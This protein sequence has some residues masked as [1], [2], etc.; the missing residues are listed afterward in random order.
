MAIILSKKE[1]G[2][3]RYVCD[4]VPV[5]AASLG[6]TAID[7][8][9]GIEY[10][11]LSSG[12]TN[13]TIAEINQSQKIYVDST[14]GVDSAGNGSIAAPY[15]TPEFALSD[16]TNTGTVTGNTNTSV[17]ITNI[18]DVDNAT[19]EVGMYLVGTGIPYGTIIVSKG[20]EGLDA[21]T[22]TISKAATSTTA[23]LSITWYKAYTLVLNGDFIATGNWHKEGFNFEF[24]NSN[25]IF[26]GRLFEITSTK[27]LPLS[28]SGGYLN[29]ISN[30]SQLIYNNFITSDVDFYFG[31]KG[32]YSIG[33]SYQ[34]YL[35][36]AVCFKSLYLD[37][38]RFDARF[39]YLA[40]LSGGDCFWNGYKYGLLGGIDVSATRLFSN[41]FLETP[42]SVNAI[43]TSNANNQLFVNDKIIGSINLANYSAGFV[44]NGDIN[45]T[46]FIGTLSQYYSD[47]IFNGNVEFS[48]VTINGTT[49][50]Q[51]ST[52]TA[53]FNGTL[54]A[55]VT[56]NGAIVKINSFQ[57]AYIG[58]NDSFGVLTPGRNSSV[59]SNGLT[60][61]NLS[62]TATLDVNNSIALNSF[63]LVNS[64]SLLLATG[65]TLNVNGELY[66]QV[67]AT[68]GGT[69]NVNSSA[70]LYMCHSQ[71][72][73]YFVTG[74][75]NI[76][77]GR[78]ELFR[79]NATENIS[80]TPSIKLDG[81]TLFM[82]GGSLICN[83]ATSLSGLIQKRSDG[84]K[85]VFKGQPYLKVANGL[86][87]LQILSN[88]GTAQDVVNFGVIT[89]GAVGFRLA[90]IFSDT[91]YGTAYAPNILVGGTTYEDTTYNF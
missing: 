64:T 84:S 88:V 41:G 81:G 10:T 44:F 49:G 42:S 32:Y 18:S 65:T 46:N 27:Y 70:K 6:D 82:D 19:L 1:Q 66:V 87:P 17:T 52:A 23:L 61:I 60:S 7:K 14:Y 20:N 63:T 43:S 4:A 36:G 50:G 9:T 75:I 30:S 56:N 15:L 45:G 62:G 34:V 91:T 48:T 37:C 39:G 79:Y 25:I 16:I 90:D 71:Y 5:H 85:V 2:F 83:E 33:T 12:W 57:G 55:T 89:N 3:T 47:F 76:L 77:G 67:L 40:R 13:S 11:Y 74:I 86:A 54:I 35:H 38:P 58:N 31:L 29:G 68:I 26:N 24:G 69:L 51:N 53:T 72:A 59:R 80:S 78:L 73:S 8:T 28:V 22:V 21:N